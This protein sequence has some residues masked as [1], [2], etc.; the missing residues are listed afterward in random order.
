MTADHVRC[1]TDLSWGVLVCMEKRDVR[2]SN[3]SGLRIVQCR[4]HAA[5]V[6]NLRWDVPCNSATTFHQYSC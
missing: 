1:L 2:H 3:S 6:E 5:A 4:M